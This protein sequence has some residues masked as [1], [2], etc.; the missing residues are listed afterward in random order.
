MTNLDLIDWR[1][2]GFSALWI[3][4]LSVLLAAFSFA[5]Y[6]ASQRRLRTRDV[7][8]WPSYQAALCAGLVLFCLGLVGSAHAWWAQVL[9]GAL[10]VAFAY[11]GWAA[12]RKREGPPA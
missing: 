8:R 3:S 9:W 5:D 12:W 7:L 2:V 11:Q 4:G 6:T 10:A 1:L